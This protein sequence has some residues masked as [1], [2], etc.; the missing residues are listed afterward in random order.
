AN[1]AVGAQRRTVPALL[2]L[3]AESDANDESWDGLLGAGLLACWPQVI[4]TADV[5]AILREPKR[6]D[7]IGPYNS[8]LHVLAD[9]LAD[10]DLDAAVDWVTRL[11]RLPVGH[12]LSRVANVAVDLVRRHL[13][14]PGALDAVC[15]LA[16]DRAQAH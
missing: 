3:V 1:L 6:S 15:T 4:S 2:P 11:G 13:D 14:H 8:F 9:E 10:E 12:S 5:F 7:Y 16:R